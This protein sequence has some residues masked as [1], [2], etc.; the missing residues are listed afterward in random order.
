M[1]ATAIT[2]SFLLESSYIDCLEVTGERVSNV[3]ACKVEFQSLLRKQCQ[4]E[5]HSTRNRPGLGNNL[6]D[7]AQQ[8]RFR[9]RRHLYRVNSVS[10]R[11]APRLWPESVVNCFRWSTLQFCFFVVLKST[12]SSLCWTWT[13]TN[14]VIRQ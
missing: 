7:L 1:E 8:S 10:V 3:E 12:E 4:L 13:E 6:A 11:R 14:K 2:C 5:C 9:G